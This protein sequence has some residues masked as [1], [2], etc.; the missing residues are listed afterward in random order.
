MGF[1]LCSLEANVHELNLAGSLER[2]LH[3]LCFLDRHLVERRPRDS[4]SHEPSRKQSCD[5]CRHTRQSA[6]SAMGIFSH[7]AF[8]RHMLYDSITKKLRSAQTMKRSDLHAKD[9]TGIVS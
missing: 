9:G 3:L 2:L 4:F 7:L 1:F 6:G 8:P 5:V